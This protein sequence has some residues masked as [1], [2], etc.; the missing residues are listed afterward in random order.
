MRYA[1]GMKLF[2]NADTLE[3][4]RNRVHTLVGILKNSCLL[5]QGTRDENKVKMHD[6]IRDVAISI[7]KEKEGFLVK[8]GREHL[9]EWP[10]KDARECC[11][12]ISLRC[13]QIDKLPD[14]LECLE[15]HTLVF[16]WSN[17]S[18]NIPD[19]FF[20]KTRKLKVLNLHF[21]SFRSLLPS[22]LRNLSNLRMLRLYGLKL[23]DISILKDLVNLEILS[24]GGFT[25][26]KLAPE[27]RHLTRLRL[28]NFED[29]YNLQVIPPNVISS[30]RRL[31]EL[32]IPRAFDKWE[33]EA[34]NNMRSKASIVELN[35][36]THLTS[37]AIH[38]PNVTFLPKEILFFEKL[39]RF[40]ISVGSRFEFL[41]EYN[42]S[43]RVLKL[44]G[45]LLK[46]EFKVLLERAEVLYL[47]KL[48]GLEKFLHN[49]DRGKFLGL[50][51]LEV[52]NCDG[53][54]YLFSPPIA[55]GLV[56]LRQ[57]KIS[58][59]ENMEEIIRNDQREGVDQEEIVF[60]QLKIMELSCLPRL[61]SFYP[62]MMKSS[63]KE[64]PSNPAQ[65]LFNEKVAFP[66]LERLNIKELGHIREI[67]DNQFVFPIPEEKKEESF[68]QLRYLDV[69]KC[70]KLVNV[71]P[72]NMLPMLQN[73]EELFVNECKSVL[74]LIEG[75]NV[76]DNGSVTATTIT[77][78]FL[79][80]LRTLEFA[81]KITK[82]RKVQSG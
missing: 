35:S 72:T 75:L 40:Q 62:K 82:S 77:Q 55:S 33:V 52:E 3:S 81:A 80:R 11:K 5:L 73:L 43:T 78:V 70:D 64:G 10:E 12:V 56:Q 19:A 58:T 24:L 59:C 31:E 61:R 39:I 38:I 79:P 22:S 74:S 49:R 2:E 29:C 54:E 68:S 46:D 1:V 76:E 69:T 21:W 36:L 48:K 28:L 30:L 14:E 9:E 16:E 50:K 18:T 32:Y 17:A 60:Q 8:H 25:I 7:A 20:N 66:A 27:I 41:G 34:T 57:L 37:L 13:E 23:A 26:E 71:I 65:S 51:F 44:D 53:I 67:W 4:A 6:V 45:I 63:T 42:S 15:L 47:N